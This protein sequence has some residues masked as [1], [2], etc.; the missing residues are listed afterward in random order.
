MMVTFQKYNLNTIFSG[1]TNFVTVI[2]LEPNKLDAYLRLLACA[3]LRLAKR[4]KIEWLK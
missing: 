1:L 2:K 3:E 4:R